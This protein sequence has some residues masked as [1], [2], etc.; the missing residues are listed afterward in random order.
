MS[1]TTLSVP[2]PE[3]VGKLYDQ[4][5]KDE[6]TY[7]QFEKF[8]HQLHIGY[9]DDPTSDVPMR[10]A[11]V[12]L[13][14]LMVERLRVDVEDRVLDLG[15]G[16]GGPATQIV[17][18]TGARVVGVSISE[19]QVKLATRLAT[20]AGVGD[21]ATFQ[22]AD[23]MRLPFEDESFDAVMALESILHMPSREQVLSE[24]RRVLRPGGRLVLTDFFERAPHTP[25]MH[26]A[27]E[28]FC[29]TAMTTMADV[30]DYVP[31][32]HRVGLRVRELLDIT[33]QTMERTWRET[34]EIVSQNDRPVDFD[35]AELFGVDEFGCLLVAADRP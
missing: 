7:E 1:D 6:H 10:E 28:G 20:E 32:L 25:G 9:W 29:R 3:E 22:R 14:E 30:D 5:L 34:L 18:T 24:A 21:R 19:E 35:L 11:V 27:I 23:A 33:E 2:V 17:R 26:P 8:N 13:T 4:I 15:C 16:I 12:R 31:M